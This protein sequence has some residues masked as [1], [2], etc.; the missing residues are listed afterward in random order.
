MTLGIIGTGF[1]GGAYARYFIGRGF[2]VTQYS[3]D[4]QFVQNRDLIKNC[5]VVL[6]CLLTPTTQEGVD[7]SAIR[8]VLPLIR[9]NQVAIVKSTVPPGTLDILQYDF[10]LIRL[11]SSPEFLSVETADH[12]V[13]NPFL[14]LIGRPAGVSDESWTQT[15]REFRMVMRWVPERT[16]VISST[17]AEIIKYA[18]NVSGV[19]NTLLYNILADVTQRAGGQW[20]TIRQA[21]LTDP[22]LAAQ[23]SQPLHKNGRGAGGPCFIKDFEAFRQVVGDHPSA[24]FLLQAVLYNN[25]L[26]LSSGK[27]VDLVNAVYPRRQS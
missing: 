1:V 6:L 13:A 24:D 4:P 25:D 26:L 23:Y 22:Y 27:D 12:D 8:E 20:D 16:F 2:R 15:E 19:L 9:P 3:L 10:P 17:E 18:H 21:L 14:T 7:L 5:D 11:V